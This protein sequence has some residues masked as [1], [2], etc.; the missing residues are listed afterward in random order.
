MGRKSC[1]RKWYAALFSKLFGVQQRVR[2]NRK[3]GTLLLQQKVQHR[4]SG[5]RDTD[6]RGHD[7]VRNAHAQQVRGLLRVAGE[8]ELLQLPRRAHRRQLGRPRVSEVAVPPRELQLQAAEQSEDSQELP[9]D[10]HPR[11]SVRLRAEVLWPGRRCGQSVLGGPTDRIPGV[12]CA[13][14]RLPG[15]QCVVCLFENSV[16]RC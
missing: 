6:L 15:S 16:S 2:N 9:K 12:Q 14:L 1:R 5:E 11:E 8:T 13:Q 10:R 4:Q 7:R 3:P